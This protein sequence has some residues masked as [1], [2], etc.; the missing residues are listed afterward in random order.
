M[1]AP[2]SNPAV[3][4]QSFAN[5]AGNLGTL[6]AALQNVV[7]YLGLLSNAINAAFPAPLTSSATYNPPNIVSGS[8][9]S[10]TVTVA[11]AALGNYV[12]ASFSLDLQGLTLSAYVSAP[13]TVTVIF[14][15]NTGGAIDLASGTLTVWVRTK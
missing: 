12:T 15:N 4:N 2:F 9:I 10:T 14:A 7:K 3:E 1:D 8:S 11:G 5:S 13:N 6:V